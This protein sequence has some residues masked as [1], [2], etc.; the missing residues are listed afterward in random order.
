MA[1]RRDGL[2]GR[3]SGVTLCNVAGMGLAFLA[4]MMLARFLGAE[5]FGRYAFALNWVFL[6]VMLVKLGLGSV[7]VRFVA[8]YVTQ[9]AWG[10]LRGLLRR[11]LM[12]QLALAL[13]VGSLLMLLAMVLPQTPS[14]WTAGTLMLSGLLLPLLVASQWVRDTFYGFQ[15]P[16][17]ALVSDVLLQKGLLALLAGAAVLG[18]LG[19]S[20]TPELAMLWTALAA[21]SAV[22][23]GALLLKRALPAARRTQPP[24]Y[25]SA[26]WL[27]MGFPMLVV[28]AAT[29]VTTRGDMLVL[30]WLA[31]ASEAG[32]YAAAD[33]K[34]V[35]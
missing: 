5:G 4:Q 16:V 23:V 35:V 17:R 3:A 12:L 31:P 15:Q 14:G 9:E 10:L 33:R 21:V 1:R 27:G 2:L 13:G 7:I 20:A 22:L 6:G 19:L 29:Q 26:G 30:G 34:S 25:A 18:G 24:S 8:T 32:I 11:T 28:D